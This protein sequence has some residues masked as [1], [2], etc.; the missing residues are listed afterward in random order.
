MDLAGAGVLVTGGAGGIGAA[1]AERL[2]AAGAVVTL[3]DID[4]GR[5]KEVAAR[6]G[7][8]FVETD[9]SQPDSLR[10]AVGAAEARAPVRVVHLNAGLT[11]PVDSLEV[12][13]ALYR[14]LLGVNLDGVYWGIRASREA[15][16]RSGGGSIVVTSSLAGLVPMPE[17]PLYSAAKGAVIALTRALAPAL[18]E[19]GILLNCVCP[20]FVD[21][22]LVP[23]AIRD[24]GFPLLS[25]EQVADA[26][27]EV[28]HAT[29]DSGT[30][31]VQ[32]GRDVIRYEFRNVPG[33]RVP[34]PDGTMVSVPPNW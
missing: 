34:G 31:L 14:R 11:T 20:G 10:A 5:G 26:V 29:T 33:A 16:R 24:S 23:T 7:A 1:V 22:P 19:D 13:E 9:V 32:P 25:S 18:R 21:T 30:Y 15:L 8:G 17:D 2:V 4:A 3:A 27:L 12:D 28:V 6:L